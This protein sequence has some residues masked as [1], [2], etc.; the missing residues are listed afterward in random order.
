MNNYTSLFQSVA[1]GLAEK[2]IDAESTDATPCDEDVVLKF[3][4][5]T[6]MT[7]PE[8]LKEFYTQFSD[9]FAFQWELNEGVW[10]CFAI[11]PISEL[12]S[13]TESWQ[14]NVR[15]FA[16]DPTS[17]NR[18]IRPE[19]RPRA[20]EIWHEMIN[21][22]PIWHEADGDHFCVCQNG[23]VVYDQ[24]DWF[25]GFGRIATTNGLL[26]GTSLFDHV[27]NWGQFYFMPPKDSWWGALAKGSSISWQA[28][29]FPPEPGSLATPES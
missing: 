6:G 8:S 1:R 26:A 27:Q 20:F 17:M 9:G 14:R 18:C 24:H 13:Q 3:E 2:G 7:M 29:F 22:I 15:Q 23:S 25:D 10:G 19:F 4:Q 21:W 28:D 12:I 16:N 5:A 11:P